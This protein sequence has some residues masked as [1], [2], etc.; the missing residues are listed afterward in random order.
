RLTDKDSAKMTCIGK[1]VYEDYLYKI[2]NESEIFDE[3]I[4]E[5]T[6]KLHGKE[7]RT[8]DIMTRK[9]NNYIFFDSKSFTP[10]IAIRTFSE[11][12]L[13]KDIERLSEAC[14]Q[15]Y[16]HIRNKFPNEYNYFHDKPCELSINIFGIVV[17]QENP[18]ILGDKLYPIVASHLNI[19][20]DSDE[21]E[22]LHTH[23][24]IVSI[25]DIE[26]YCFTKT[27]M[28]SSLNKT[29]EECKTSPAWLSGPLNKNISYNPYSVFIKKLKKDF[30]ETLS[31]L[32][33][34]YQL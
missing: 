27:D 24:G 12:A 10:K 3:V 18:F 19:D 21:F 7:R 32:V 9:N 15:M 2:I 34:E 23:I 1:E 14:I 26:K 8:A 11:E 30:A 31:M 5:Q 17:V 13:K 4:S 33:K 20:L 16:K 22:W 6:Y 29:K 25:Y 28:C